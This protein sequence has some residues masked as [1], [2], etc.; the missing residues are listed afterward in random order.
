M[1]RDL[2]QGLE[3]KSVIADVMGVE[4]VR[5]PVIVER[6]EKMFGERTMPPNN[7]LQADVPVLTQLAEM[8]GDEPV[9]VLTLIK[10]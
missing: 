5:N 3:W 9:T 1:T 7:L 10:Q 8:V 6:I 4:L 2:D